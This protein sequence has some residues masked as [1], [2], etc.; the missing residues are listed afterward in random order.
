MNQIPTINMVKTGHNIAYLRQK[1]GMTVKDLQAVFG[2]AT[3]QAIYKWQNGTTLPTIDN[4]IVLAAIFQVHIEEILV[5]DASDETEANE[6]AQK[7]KDISRKKICLQRIE[8][9]WNEKFCG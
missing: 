2:F 6:M 1:K 8:G 9:T 4:L 5:V 3:P 7:I